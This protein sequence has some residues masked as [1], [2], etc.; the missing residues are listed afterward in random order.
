MCWEAH[1][2]KTRIRERWF[3]DFENCVICEHFA[4]N[5]SLKEKFPLNLYSFS[6][7]SITS[8]Y[9]GR[10]TKKRT[11]ESVVLD[12]LKIVWFVN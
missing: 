7:R 6:A 5:Y 2:K 3:G 12:C 11:R 4:N 10:S 9:V 8:Y 1:E